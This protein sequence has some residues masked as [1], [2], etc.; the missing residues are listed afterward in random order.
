MQGEFLASG[1]KKSE[2]R[3]RFKYWSVLSCV[4]ANHRPFFV[5]FTHG[6]VRRNEGPM[7]SRVPNGI[8][9]VGFGAGVV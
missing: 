6:V 4:L 5:V 9:E 3:L 8:V 2:K 1:L 7:E